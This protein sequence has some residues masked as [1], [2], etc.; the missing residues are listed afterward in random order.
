MTRTPVLAFCGSL[1]AGSLNRGLLRLAQRVAPELQFVGEQLVG[2]LPLFNPDLDRD[3]PASVLEFR[4]LARAARAVVAASPEYVLGPS[5]VTKNAFDWLSGYGALDDKPVLL[6]SASAG[7]TGGLRGLVGL[8]STVQALGG[9]LVDP[10][11][12]SLAASR[13]DADGNVF[14]PTVYQRVEFA[15]DE[16]RTL[17]EGSPAASSSWSLAR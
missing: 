12:V 4:Q 15:L 10:V 13:L 16:V 11:S 17:L 7:H 2:Q 6:M 8:F 14:D 5:G 1:R 9:V 3:P